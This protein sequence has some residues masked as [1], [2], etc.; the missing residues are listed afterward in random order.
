MARSENLVDLLADAPALLDTLEGIGIDVSEW[1]TLLDEILAQLD[2]IGSSVTDSVDSVLALTPAD[3]GE[4]AKAL[5]N[6]SVD[7]ILGSRADLDDID[8]SID[9][10][11]ALIDDLLDG[12]APA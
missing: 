11:L 2:G 8:A 1:R 6:A 9:D 12:G 5:T 3:F 7:T 4:D 10:A